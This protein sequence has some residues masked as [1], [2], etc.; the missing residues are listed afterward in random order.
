MKWSSPPILKEKVEANVFEEAFAQP[1]QHE[2]A[3]SNLKETKE[4][5]VH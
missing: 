3:L 2:K 4:Y 1:G 5:A